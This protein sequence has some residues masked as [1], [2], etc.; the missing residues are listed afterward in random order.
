MLEAYFLP[1]EGDR[2][3]SW[4]RLAV[5]TV[6]AAYFLPP[7]G[8]RG[9]S[10]EKLAVLTVL[11]AYFLPPEG[12]R[13]EVVG[14]GGDVQVQRHKHLGTRPSRARQAQPDT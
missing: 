3:A 13:G 14:P 7:E 6:L 4:E 12:D 2:G 5:L 10:W 9:G 1:P 8:D 11:E